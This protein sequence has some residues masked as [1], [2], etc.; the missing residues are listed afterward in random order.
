M[1]MTRLGLAGRW[2]CKP[3]WASSNLDTIP[4]VDMKILYI[5]V[6]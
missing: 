2:T 6:R 1:F 3:P 5:G 4:D